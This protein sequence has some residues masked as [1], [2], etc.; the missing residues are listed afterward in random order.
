MVG[1]TEGA[2]ENEPAIDGPPLTVDG[3]PVALVALVA[4]D[5]CE[6]GPRTEPS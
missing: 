2:R 5:A 1:A 3:M 6:P 4:F